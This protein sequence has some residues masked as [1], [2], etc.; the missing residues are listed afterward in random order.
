MQEALQLLSGDRAA[1]SR[2]LP[3]CLVPLADASWKAWRRRDTVTL[4]ITD[5]GRSQRA[6]EVSVV[7]PLYSRV[8]FL[9]Y[10]VA[11]FS[12]DLQ[13]TMHTD[14][15]LI[16]VLDD[17]ARSAELRDIAQQVYHLYRIPFRIIEMS[18]NSGYSAA[19]NAGARLA[20]G[21]L[22]LLLNSDVI[23]KAPHWLSRLVN[24]FDHLPNCAVLGCQLLYE[25]GSIQH[26]GMQFRPF[27]D[28]PDTWL[29]IHP[30][31]GMPPDFDLEK[32][33]RQVCA[34]T[35]A[36][37]MIDRHIYN[38]LG[39]LAEDYVVGDFEDADLCHRVTERGGAIW[40]EPTVQLYH[41]ERQ[42]MVTQGSPAVRHLLTLINMWKHGNRWKLQLMQ[43]A[44][45][46]DCRL[47]DGPRGMS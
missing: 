18:R 21:R 5:Y 8:D 22:L 12:N 16:Y 33:P 27:P 32:E 37:L 24:A 10:Q 1:V 36:C 19:S 35:G 44:P 15:E 46:D 4:T 6:P 39:G 11:A 42:S 2:L 30:L 28:V 29:C 7:V 34:V 17:P 45:P 38:E 43:L 13:F 41:I 3:N 31:K 40:Y 47:L 14:V 9:R 26:A 20:R 25:D 23:P